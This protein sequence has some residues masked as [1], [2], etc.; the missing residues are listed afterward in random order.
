MRKICT[1]AVLTVFSAFLQANEV[2]QDNLFNCVDPDGLTLD[3][4]CISTKIENTQSYQSFDLA[5]QEQI[6]DLGGNAMATMIFHQEKMWIQVIAQDEKDNT[7]AL[8]TIKSDK[9]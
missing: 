1:V 3:S 9:D 4:Q 2:K 7:L 5:F 8:N 6:S